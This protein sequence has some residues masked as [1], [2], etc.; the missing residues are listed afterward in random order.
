LRAGFGRRSIADALI[1][2]SMLL[3]LLALTACSDSASSPSSPSSSAQGASTAEFDDSDCNLQTVLDPNKPGSP[4]N[5]IP[6]ERNPNGDSELA[7]LM[8]V[9]V[10]DLRDTRL[11]I[12]AGEAVPALFQ[13]HRAMRCAWPTV[14]DDRDEAYD[15]RAQAYLSA[16][17]GFDASPSKDSY[18]AV[19]ASCIACHQVSCAGVIEFITSL[20]W[21]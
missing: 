9:F 10:D 5:L 12:E 1:R 16:V 18:N 19:V 4:G 20:R 21:E 3:V 17:R 13:T 7:V 6:S 2:F 11:L 14:P 15:M 8:R